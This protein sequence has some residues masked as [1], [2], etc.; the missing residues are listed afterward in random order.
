MAFSKSNGVEYY[1]IAKANGVVSDTG[2]LNAV[3]ALCSKNDVLIPGLTVKI[4]TTLGD[5]LPQLDTTGLF[6][7]LQG[8]SKSWRIFWGDGSFDTIVYTTVT[9]THTYSSGGQYDVTVVGNPNAQ[10]KWG[11]GTGDNKVISIELWAKNFQRGGFQFATNLVADNAPDIPNITTATTFFN[12]CTSLTT[13]GDWGSIVWQA[14]LQDLYFVFTSCTVFNTDIGNWQVGNATNFQNMFRATTAFDQDIG[15]WDMS[16]AENI[17][18]MFRDATAFN[19]GGV[20]GVG[21]GIDSWQLNNLTTTNL[22]FEGASAFNQTIDSWDMSK[23][24]NISSMFNNATS[25][26]KDL[27]SWNLSPDLATGTSTSVVA[28]KLVDSTADFVSAEVSNSTSLVYNV[29]TGEFADITAHTATELTLDADI[30]TATGQSYRVFNNLAMGSVFNNASSFNANISSWNTLGATSLAGVFAN[31]SSFDS[32]ISSWDTRRNTSLQQTFIQA[33]VFNQ[34]IGAW[35]TG[36]VTTMFY[37]FRS[38]PAFNNGGSDT[39]RN[40]DVSNVESM[41]AAFFSCSSFNQPLDGWRPLKCTE[42]REAF[43][44]AVSFDGDCT[45]WTLPTTGDVNF[46]S[47]FKDCSAFTGTGVETWNVER[48]TSFNSAFIQTQVNFPLTHPNYWEMR[49]GVN[50]GSI[51]NGTPFNGGLASGASGRNCEMQFSTLV[52]DSYDLSAMFSSAVSFNQDISTDLTNNYWDMT[53]VTSMASMFV[54][55]NAFNQDIGN[56][57]TAACTDFSDILFNCFLWNHDISGWNIASLLNATRALQN[58]AFSTTNY[59]L[60]LDNTTG[61]AS[62]STIQNNVGFG[63]GATQYTSGGAAEAGRNILTGT[64]GWTITDGGPV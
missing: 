14:A 15:D 58:T 20:G 41:R 52:T 10:Y 60:L 53:R 49:P 44:G 29:T 21:L 46:A 9:P 7:N 30:F 3:Q 19:N 31:A 27:N 34:N 47:A 50:V 23:V 13:I 55:A 8:P 1:N 57:N 39:I 42:W 54:N 63:V 59:D 48:V 24:T 36:N 22:L 32:D 64:Y 18:Q 56:W 26:N 38:C 33:T 40:W 5:G 6:V 35:E 25:F 2:N 12:G 43:R 45:G 17:G 51:F 4:D 62:Q 16:S 37:C 61:W 28:N 11:D